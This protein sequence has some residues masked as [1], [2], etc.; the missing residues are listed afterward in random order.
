MLDYVQKGIAAGRSAEEIV[1]AGLPA[2]AAHEGAPQ[3]QVAYD[4]LTAKA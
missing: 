1:K 3:L 4:E 2:F